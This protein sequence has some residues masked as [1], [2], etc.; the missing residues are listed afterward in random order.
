MVQTQEV[1]HEKSAGV[2]PSGKEVTREKTQVSSP[3]TEEYLTIWSINNLIYYLGG[4]IEVLLLFRFT[5]RILGA[6]PISPFVSFI[7]MLSRIFESPFRGIFRMAVSEGIETSAVLEPST[8]FA[9]LV[10]AILTVAI[11]E[12]I[13]IITI[14]RD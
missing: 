3:E 11:V 1:I 2:T 8:L 13:K 10:Y 7:Y 14:T 4:A 5:L 6:N 9:M 12:L